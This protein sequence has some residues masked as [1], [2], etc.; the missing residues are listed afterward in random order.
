MKTT[1]LVIGIL[2]VIIGLFMSSSPTWMWSL[3]VLGVVGIIWG[4]MSK[5]AD[6]A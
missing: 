2:L 4:W 5:G 6:Q 1:L 3:I